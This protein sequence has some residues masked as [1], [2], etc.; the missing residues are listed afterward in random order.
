MKSLYGGFIGFVWSSK[1]W[2]GVV[3]ASFRILGIK[4]QFLCSTLALIHIKKIIQP[5]ITT[6]NGILVSPSFVG[7]SF[8]HLP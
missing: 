1:D 5:Q 4:K 3:Y 7:M 2:M 8:L 6:K